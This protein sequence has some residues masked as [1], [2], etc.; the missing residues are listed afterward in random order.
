MKSFR[1]VEITCQLTASD[2]D[3]A[4]RDCAEVK[5]VA[6]EDAAAASTIQNRYISITSISNWFQRTIDSQKRI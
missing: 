5:P 4:Y 1:S 6:F 2:W 3:L